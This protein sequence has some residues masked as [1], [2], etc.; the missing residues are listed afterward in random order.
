MVSGHAADLWSSIRSARSFALGLSLTRGEWIANVDSDDYVDPKRTRSCL[1]FIEKNPELGVVGTWVMAVDP[2]GERCREHE[3]VETWFNRSVDLQ[4]PA[5]WIASN[6]LC[7]SSTMVRKSLFEKYGTHEQE[8]S[9][10]NDYEFWT[11]LL[12]MGVGLGVVQENL[13]AIRVL[14]TS[15][16]HGDPIRSFL[17]ISYILSKN[18]IPLFET[19]NR[20]KD[21][22]DAID[23]WV[24]DKRLLSLSQTQILVLLFR[25]LEP[26]NISNFD[27]Y[28]RESTSPL[29]LL[30]TAFRFQ[31]KGA[32]LN[33]FRDFGL[34]DLLPLKR[35]MVYF[36]VKARLGRPRRKYSIIL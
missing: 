15:V 34:F 8:L 13:T 24:N 2:E 29:F 4:E 23:W 22:F 18:V 28:L 20:A 27:A 26:R 35:S 21:W 7:N 36:M 33:E 30:R 25:L 14:P 1:D 3:H 11:R 19:H 10:T 9:R 16:T 17:E 31:A 32:A 6:F 12:V 5:N